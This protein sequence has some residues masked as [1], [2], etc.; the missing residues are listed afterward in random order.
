MRR[1]ETYAEPCRF[2]FAM[3]AP[4]VGLRLQSVMHVPC[5]YTLARPAAHDGIEQHRG[6][7]AAAE[8]D[9][10]AVVGSEATQRRIDRIGDVVHSDAGCVI[11][12]HV[13]GERRPFRP[14]PAP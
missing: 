3:R 4:R 9:D 12:R 5:D 7:D 1:A 13:A 10:D 6:I 14:A 8:G 11:G 2:V